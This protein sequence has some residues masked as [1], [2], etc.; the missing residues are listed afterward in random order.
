MKK[1]EGKVEFYRDVAGDWRWRIKAANGRILADSGE[2]YK[3]RRSCEE[4]FS[5]V[6]SEAVAWVQEFPLEGRWKK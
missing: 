4:G 5:T 2:G 3:R 1:R 6:T